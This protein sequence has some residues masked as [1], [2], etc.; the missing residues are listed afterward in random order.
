MSITMPAIDTRRDMAD[1]YLRVLACL[2][3]GYSVL[4][5]GIAY[6]GIP[7][8]YVGEMLFL[9]GFVMLFRSGCLFATFT[10]FPNLVLLALG[11]WVVSRTVP[12]VGLYG[13]DALRDSVVVLYA[14]FAFTVC[15]LLL[16]KP[17]RLTDAL[18]FLGRFAMLFGASAGLL[19]I[20][21]KTAL[22]ASFSWPGAPIPI[23]FI[24]SGEVATHVAGAALYALLLRKRVSATWVV[25]LLFGIGTISAQSRGGMLAIL[26]PVA[27]AALIAGRVARLSRIV[28]VIGL[29]FGLGLA[30]Q[31]EI[32][33][34]DVDERSGA[35]QARTLSA[36]QFLNNAASIVNDNASDELS[37]SKRWRLIWWETIQDYTFRG[38]YFWTGKGFGIGLAVD[39]GFVVWESEG[40]TTVRSPHNVSITMLARA[41]VPGLALWLLLIV[42]WFGMMMRSMFEARR[43][44]EE[45]WAN[46][47]L[48]L[49]GYLLS[50]FINASFDVAL[51]GP[52][53]GIWFWSLFGLGVAAS[54]IYRTAGRERP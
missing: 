12:Y 1:L 40:E 31:I 14:G 42:S 6:A 29:L 28:A 8:L 47:F 2:L 16:E 10:A 27:L 33:I 52:M 32:P 37:G 46:A 54:M 41:G 48:Y 15:A 22:S 17:A 50:I 38:P 24:R 5:K 7:P 20:L 25:M 26:V 39:D 19:Y 35:S 44:G 11:G 23:M 53:L 43:R 18:R 49:A 30:L 51:E 45:D 4:G 36:E 34:S 13:I 9:A 3:V 21:S